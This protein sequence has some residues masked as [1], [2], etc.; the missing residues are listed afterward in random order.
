MERGARPRHR[1]VLETPA[2]MEATAEIL[3]M[4]STVHA[5]EITQV[6]MRKTTYYCFTVK[7]H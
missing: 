1:G 4:A 6:Q 3:D 7:C 2:E 5:Q